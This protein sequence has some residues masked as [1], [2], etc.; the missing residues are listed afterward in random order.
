MLDGHAVH[1]LGEYRDAEA[2]LAYIG[3]HDVDVLDVTPT[4]LQQLV[5][6]G[7]A[8]AG[9][10]VLLVGGEAVEESLW[11]RVC[12]VP[13]LVVHDLYGPTEASVDAYG[14]HGDAGG[15]R[16]AY[17]LS[18]V[19]TY[20]LDAGLLP[21]P[22][23][24]AGELYVAGSA[25]AQGYSGSPGLTA[26]RFTA[27]PYGGRPGERMYRTG[28]LAR[29]NAAGVL[30]FAGRADGQVKL[31]GFRIELGEIEAA[32]RSDPSVGQAAVI[33]REDAPGA[34]QLV[35]YLVPGPGTAPDLS[36]V[37][38]RAAGMRAIGRKA[39][40]FAVGL[41]YRIVSCPSVRSFV[42]FPSN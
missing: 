39:T 18:G 19:R 9:L 34:R 14:W 35:G 15:G 16:S 33:V 29:W 12:A 42:S 28:D 25:L 7:L 4:Y 5:E 27:D 41:F 20:V 11:R 31:R 3:E 1:V 38:A 22:V 2:V 6:V 13:G 36:A 21:V 40:H 8:A 10:S 32:L 23:G 24:V 30:E 26:E 17:R 37:R